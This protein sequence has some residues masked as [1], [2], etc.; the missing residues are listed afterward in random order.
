VWI[1]F[2][3]RGWGVSFEV[4]GGVREARTWDAVEES[5]G[6]QLNSFADWDGELEAYCCLV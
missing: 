1:V 4:E 2:W 6:W 3:E 5:G